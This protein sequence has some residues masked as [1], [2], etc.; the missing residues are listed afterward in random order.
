[1]DQGWNWM[2][3]SLLC[4]LILYESESRDWTEM[5]WVFFVL[6]YK[7]TQFSKNYQVTKYELDT[8]LISIIKF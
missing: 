4:T 7:F 1:M 5:F 6:K 8:K 2:K 3:F